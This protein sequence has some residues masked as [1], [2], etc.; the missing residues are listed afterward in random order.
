LIP[1]EIIIELEEEQPSCVG[2]SEDETIAVLGTNIEPKL[3]II[4]I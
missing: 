4:D 1:I 2:V 3:Q